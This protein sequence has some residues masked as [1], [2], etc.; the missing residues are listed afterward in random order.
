MNHYFV[1]FKLKF[2]LKNVNK[3]GSIGS[4]SNLSAPI[5]RLIAIVVDVSTAIKYLP[6][7]AFGVCNKGSYKRTQVKYSEMLKTM[8]T[9]MKTCVETISNGRDEEGIFK[10]QVQSFLNNFTFFTQHTD[11][12]PR[13][14]PMISDTMVPTSQVDVDISPDNCS[15]QSS[16]DLV[17]KF[18]LEFDILEQLILEEGVHVDNSQQMSDNFND[19]WFCNFNDLGSMTSID[20]SLL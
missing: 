12:D 3:K 10:S 20:F 17:D 2:K 7:V 9:H 8:S 13:S 16:D 4:L 14:P 18:P 15:N 11:A 19:L 5:Y 1:E 6:L